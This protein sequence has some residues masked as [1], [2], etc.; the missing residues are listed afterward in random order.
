[1]MR[2]ALV[3]SASARYSVRFVSR[4]FDIVELLG[5]TDLPLSLGDISR[6]LGMVK[7]SG[8]RLL[9][10][11]EHRGYVERICDDVRYHLGPELMTLI[12]GPPVQP[13]LID[14]APPHM[15]ALPELFE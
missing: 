8:F 3:V 9:R 11:L 7:S 1:M 14:T 15:E 4:A 13:R 5:D 12:R 2:A 10:T 6:R